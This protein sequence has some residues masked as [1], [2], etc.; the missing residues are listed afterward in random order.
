M[1]DEMMKMKSELLKTIYLTS[2]GQFLAIVATVVSLIL[3]FI[4]K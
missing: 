1:K 3:I 2:V 4:K